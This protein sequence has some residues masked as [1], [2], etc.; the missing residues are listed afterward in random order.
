MAV[1]SRTD[2]FSFGVVLYEMIAGRV[3]FEGTSFGDVISGILGN[4]PVPLARY[5]YDVPP[6]L[7]RIVSKA[8]AK[9]RE[10]RYQTSKDMLID[11]KRLKQRLDV[12][13]EFEHS[14]PPQW[15]RDAVVG[16]RSGEANSRDTVVVDSTPPPPIRTTSS[17]EYLVT[18]LKRHK[19]ATF[20]VLSIAVIAVV[21]MTFMGGRQSNRLRRD[22]AVRE[23][24]RRP[25]DGIDQ[26]R[27]D[28]GNHRPP[29]STSKA[30]G[31]LI[32]LS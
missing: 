24:Y 28:R 26:R 23:S 16:R 31:D 30:Q 5:A 20:L 32:R 27:N 25:K 1:D 12:E 13:A 18:E 11:L 22:T 10:Q 29:S 15:A 7:E 17:A 14:A 4:R 19:K 6:E 8:L 3:P 9:D 2:I 21:A